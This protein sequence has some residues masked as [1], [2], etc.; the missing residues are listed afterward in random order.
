MGEKRWFC[1]EGDRLVSWPKEYPPEGPCYF[2][3]KGSSHLDTCGMYDFG[4]SKGE[5]VSHELK[6]HESRF[7]EVSISYY[8][9]CGKW[10]GKV[11]HLRGAEVADLFLSEHLTQIEG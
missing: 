1:V 5:S 8:C 4:P 6:T 3:G 2:Q 7:G 10:K 11:P 9:T